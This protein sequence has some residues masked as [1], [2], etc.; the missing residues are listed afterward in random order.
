MQRYMIYDNHDPI[1]FELINP[2]NIESNT[3]F[4]RKSS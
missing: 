4:Y 2:I 1:V 3:T